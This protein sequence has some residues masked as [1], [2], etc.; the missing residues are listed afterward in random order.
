M[1]VFLKREDCLLVVVDI[2]ER[3][4]GAMDAGFKDTFLKNSIV[5]IETAKASG[6]PLVVSEQYPKGLGKTVSEIS[7]S[8]GDIPCLEKFSFSCYREKALKNAID[9]TGK[10]AAIICGIETHV[11]VMQTVLDLMAAGYSVAVASDAVC[12]RRMHDR[13]T[14]LEAMGRSGALIYSTETIAFMLME[15]AGTPLFKQISPLFKDL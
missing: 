7:R 10:R 11:C 5:L 9:S 14:A 6:I 1:S 4:Y 3:L 13:L 15:K 12:S 8:L 2:Q